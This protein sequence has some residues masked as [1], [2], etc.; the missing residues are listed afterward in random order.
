MAEAELQNAQAAFQAGD[1]AQAGHLYQQALR[2]NPRDM[3]ALY[4]LGLVCIEAQQFGHAEYVFH[5]FV[6]LQ[7]QHAD[8]HCIRGVALA[9]L[10]RRQEALACLERALSLRPDSVE[11]IS[12]H[13]TV[14]FELGEHQRAMTELDRALAIDPRHAFSWHNRGNALIAMERPEEAVESYS[15]ALE[16]DPAFQLAAEAREETLFK[17]GRLKRSPPGFTRK[18]FDEFSVHYDQ[19]MRSTLI[20]RGPEI[21][22]QLAERVIG[23][24]ENRQM[25]ILDL[26]CGTGFLGEAFSDFAGGAPI[27]GIDIS[28][29]MIEAARARGRYRSIILGDVDAE[30]SADGPE[31]DLMLAADSIIYFGDLS[32]FFSGVSHRLVPGGWFLFTTEAASDGEGWD[33]PATNRFRHSEPYLRNEASRCALEFV[34]IENCTIRYEHG[35]PVAGFAVAL[36]KPIQPFR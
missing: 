8:A 36:R 15:R 24:R 29:R 9:R 2:N 32:V 22:H 4:G 35:V 18:L 30:L 3:Q 26:G 28:P 13:G 20:Y 21:L 10:G 11:A 23:T 1:L 25:R 12:N 34:E 6:R 14:L 19:T 31:Y 27:D 16:I 33:L 7:P 5:E 17:L